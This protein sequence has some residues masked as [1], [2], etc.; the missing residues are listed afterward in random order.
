MKTLMKALLNTG[1]AIAAIAVMSTPAL[2]DDLLPSAHY[3][4]ELDRCIAEIRDE[5]N[6]DDSQRLQHRVT[7]IDKKNVWYEFVIETADTREIATSTCRAWR[8]DDRTV[9]TVAPRAAA[10]TQLA[11]NR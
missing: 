4:D 2:A 6:I 3:Q 7:R 5:L 8:F 10:E 1:M 9:A 11:E